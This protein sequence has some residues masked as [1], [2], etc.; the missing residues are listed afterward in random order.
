MPAWLVKLGFMLGKSF[1]GDEALKN[2]LLLFVC[3][4][5]M[6]LAAATVL[7]V[8]LL[9]IPFV[10]S[11]KLA[12]F[13]SSAREV[14]ALA[15]TADDAQGIIIPWEEVASAWAVLH[16]QDFSSADP[17]AIRELARAWV[18]RNE[19]HSGGKDRTRTETHIYY[20][21][22]SFDQ[23]MDQLGFNAEQKAQAQAFLQSF[24][25]GGLKPLA[26]W[27]ARAGP[28]WA[29]PVPG[30]DTATD[31]TTGYGFRVHPITMQPEMHWGIDIAAPEGTPVLA[32]QAGTVTETSTDGAFGNYVVIQGGG[33]EAR[34]AHLSSFSARRGEQVETGQ[35]IGK[36]G[37]TGLSTG[38]HLDFGLKFGGEWQNPMQY[39]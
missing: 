38:P 13:I 7:P 34:Y 1:F 24:K 11:E 8:L 31:I 5:L 15:K 18:V 33:F 30:H 19:T 39:F 10:T 27:K 2:L 23:V 17:S 29:W 16:E 9:Q 14:S 6:A 28:G 3:V 36:V 35:E 22:R 4:V 25:E 20:S 21:L 32:A 37:N 12:D 26:G